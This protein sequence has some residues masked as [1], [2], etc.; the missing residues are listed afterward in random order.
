M[1]KYL[2]IIKRD[3]LRIVKNPVALI[4]TLG[5]ALIPCLY[6]W[7]NIAANWDPYSNTS[8]IKVAV[9][10][11]D[12]QITLK[13]GQA[14]SAGAQIIDELKENSQLKWEFVDEKT[15]RDGVY[16]GSYYAAFII[17]SDFSAS[18]TDV[19]EGDATP[20]N[21]DY[22]I[23]EK[24]NPIAPK[25]T[26]TAASTL[27]D[28]ISQ[29]FLEVASKT[30]ADKIK[31]AGQDVETKGTSDA[32]GL[33]AKLD[34]LLSS[35]KDS[36]ELLISTQDS[37]NDS[38]QAL[39][40]AKDSLTT[41]KNDLAGGA[42][43]LSEAIDELPNTQEKLQIYVGSLNEQLLSSATVISQTNLD[44]TSALS[45]VNAKAVT[46]ISYISEAKSILSSTKERT[47]DLRNQLESAKDA[48]GRSGANSTLTSDVTEKLQGQIDALDTSIQDQASKID[49]LDA[50]ITHIQDGQKANQ[51]LLDSLGSLG[52]Q[53]AD[54]NASLLSDFMQ[55]TYPALSKTLFALSSDGSELST[56]SSDLSTTLDQS[57]GDLGQVAGLI[58][59]TSHTLSDNK[60]QLDTIIASVEGAKQDVELISKSLESEFSQ[61][62]DSIDTQDISLALSKPI[63]IEEHDVFAVATY[64][65]GIAPFFTNVSLWVEGIAL[66]V[67]FKLELDQNDLDEIPSARIS[68]ISRLVLF[69]LVG[70]LQALFVS[71]GNLV[72]GIQ[73]EHPLAYIGVSI[74]ASMCFISII[75]ALT[76]AF[77][78][79]GRALA[80][81]ILVLQVPGSS[82]TYPIEMMPSFF[83]AI[84]PYLPFSYANSAMREAIAGFFGLTYLTDCLILLLFGAF[85][86]IL[87]QLAKEHLTGVHALFDQSLNTSDLF[88]SEEVNS[89]PEVFEQSLSLGQQSRPK[90]LAKHIRL[91]FALIAI[92]TVLTLVVGHFIVQ[93]LLVISLWAT[94]LLILSIY[95]VLLYAT[96][97]KQQIRGVDENTCEGR[98][99]EENTTC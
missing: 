87:G 13:D 12:Q 30:I 67:V 92:S 41:I 66:I 50:A 8:S 42:K 6:A 16:N 70:I 25:V 36:S 95:I 35:L 23:N 69:W 27:Q 60:E 55:T 1:D 96:Q 62:V 56:K 31:S 22:L 47:E 2:I 18:I 34:N 32:E 94:V 19:L 77:K 49:A 79:F 86:L 88:V 54:D 81:L 51:D 44:A 52:T 57:I 4:V 72:I 98:S 46:A 29:K 75:Y 85:A 14:I 82:G 74:L 5:V 53:V 91:A 99:S 97:L 3:L 21:I 37:L 38:S 7:L 80:F 26:E 11:N 65:S 20:A 76:S 68:Y 93:K 33:S 17:P 24:L 78:H 9:V 40:S 59:S 90:D 28:Q 15:A 43:N 83:N 61:G 89:K 63:S 39:N 71:V 73:C 64:G 45:K 10:N 48:L 58:D 84:A